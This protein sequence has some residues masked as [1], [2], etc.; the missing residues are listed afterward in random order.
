VFAECKSYN[1]FERK[2]VQRMRLLASQF[3]G[4]T[5][6]FA[7]LKD[8]LKPKE[9]RLLRPFVN[10][11]R[12]YWR[13]DRPSNPVLILTATELFAEEEPPRCWGQ[14]S[15]YVT[16]APALL[17]LCDLTQQRY[18]DMQPWHD[19]LEDRWKR[20]DRKRQSHGN[21]TAEHQKTAELTEPVDPLWRAP[22]DAN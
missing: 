11:R 17:H 2:D 7:T 20:R 18:L 1:D 3:P 14:E 13:E 21:R 9:K 8:S 12:R 4:A 16:P 10:R 15:K 22:G 5:L 19:W 6:V